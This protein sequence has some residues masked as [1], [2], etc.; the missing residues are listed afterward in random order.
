M[1]M[2][3]ILTITTTIIIIDNDDNNNTYNDNNNDQKAFSSRARNAI[4]LSNIGS[5]DSKRAPSGAFNFLCL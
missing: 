5:G 4:N 2:T 1:P 3:T